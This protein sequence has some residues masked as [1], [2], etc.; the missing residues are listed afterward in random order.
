[1]AEL[2]RSALRAARNAGAD[3]SLSPQAIFA[4]MLAYAVLAL[5][6]L[7][8]ALG[9]ER[10]PPR[11]FLVEIGSLLGLL[12]L[13]MLAV[14][15]LT[16]GRHRWMARGAGD[17]LLQFHRNTGLFAW[18]F[19]A[20]HPLLL[21]LGDASFAAWLDPR[22]GLLRSVSVVGLIVALSAIVVSSLWRQKFGLS[23]EAWRT[24]HVV[25]AFGVVAGGLGHALMGAHHTA[26]LVTQVLLSGL[27]AV[28]L[29]LVLE[30]R[31]LRPWRLR[32]RPWRVLEVEE[33]RADCTR[34]VLGAEGHAG[35]PFRAGQYAWLTLGDT[36]FSLQQHPFSMSS[37]PDDPA[38]IEFV[39]K[40]LGDF[41][42][43]LANVEIGSRAYLEGPYGVFS[44][45]EGEDR[46]AVFV[47]G[48]IG[49]TPVLS[50]LR[51]RRERK[52]QAPV[53][54]VYAN[55]NQNEI[56]LLEVIEALAQ[57]LPLNVTHVLARPP[58]QW[59]GETGYVD[60]DTLDRHLP[61]DA[62]DIDYFVCGPPPMMD[63]VEAA[64]SARGVDTLRLRSER[65]DLV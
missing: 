22:E 40:Q 43:R 65:F 31:L 23:Y 30:T 28:P 13:G 7:A 9:I 56:V 27:I 18:I 33:R 59:D 46:R 19:V 21:I 63:S 6:P 50:M 61:K 15:L 10:P 14:Q 54:L 36:P 44:M 16:S 60:A 34:L 12:G 1:M 25:L 48:G 47:V 49:V 20:C 57:A 8:L 62:P 11:D 64:L 53:W 5:L 55:E 4:W 38:R 29:L 41:T 45:P 58:D 39:V 3:M 51:T 24:V 52:L 32:R 26:G 2:L 37:S 35:M 42:R 17:N